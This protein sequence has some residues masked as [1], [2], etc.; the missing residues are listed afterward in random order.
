MFCRPRPI[1]DLGLGLQNIGNF[2]KALKISWFRR[3]YTSKSFWLKLLNE[4]TKISNINSIMLSSNSELKKI[5]MDYNNPFW[6]QA[7]SALELCSNFLLKDDPTSYFC[8]NILNNDQI[9]PTISF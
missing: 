3:T 4:N 8:L 6:T 2:W 7:F 5:F 9:T 1:K